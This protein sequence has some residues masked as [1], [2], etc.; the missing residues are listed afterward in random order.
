MHVHAEEP[1]LSP[2]QRL[3]HRT[4]FGRPLRYAIAELRDRF[5]EASLEVA[6]LEVALADAAHELEA[7]LDA[8]PRGGAGPRVAHG[9][10]NL[11]R[12]QHPLVGARRE[13]DRAEDEL[14]PEGRE[15]AA[16]LP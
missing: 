9:R 5:P 11:E 13:L 4:V 8:S 12:V 3:L 14:R 1:E 15:P 2:I 16:D 7:A 10:V 6:A